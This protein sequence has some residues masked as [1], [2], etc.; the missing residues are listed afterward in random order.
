MFC[1]LAGFMYFAS[2]FT[3]EGKGSN[4]VPY[5]LFNVAGG[6]AEHEM[7]LACINSERVSQHMQR[8]EAVPP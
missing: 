6:A 4:F 8:N 1:I 3:V 7:V 5:A 2:T